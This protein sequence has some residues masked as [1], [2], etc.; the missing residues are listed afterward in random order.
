MDEK[1]VENQALISFEGPV[2]ASA[3]LPDS[4]S[5]KL[6]EG[7]Y[8]VS[9]SVYSGASIKIPESRKTEC[10]SV[11]K[12]GILGVFGSSDEECFEIVIPETNIEY[13]LIGGGKSK[14]YLLESQ[15]EKGNLE[16]RVDSLPKPDS[17]EQLQLNFEAFSEK[18]VGVGA[19]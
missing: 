13:A 14:V 17:I 3:Y 15:L 5:V 18:R 2:V 11:P 6:T 10:Q 9:V 1:N 8:N 4:R 7:F 12:S 19:L 16:F